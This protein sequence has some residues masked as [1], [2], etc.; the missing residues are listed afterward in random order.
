MGPPPCALPPPPAV[1]RH[2]PAALQV[3]EAGGGGGGGSARELAIVGMGTLVVLP[4]S[5]QPTVTSL[6]RAGSVGVFCVLYTCL[7]VAHKVRG[8]A[9]RRLL[10]R[11]GPACRLRAHITAVPTGPRLR[12]CPRRHVATPRR[13]AA[14]PTA[15]W[16]RKRYAWWLRRRS[17]SR[18]PASWCLASW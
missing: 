14:V 7:M 11:A 5:L 1:A 15:L 18:S 9:R 16:R 17:C 10:S 6:A 8:R 2:S 12:A 13:A 3:W 4:L